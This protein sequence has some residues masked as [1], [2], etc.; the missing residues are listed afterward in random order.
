MKLAL[1]VTGMVVAST[2]LERLICE[3][4]KPYFI[5]FFSG[6][7]VFFLSER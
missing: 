5:F 7:S 4:T 1:K 6:V 2:E 3:L